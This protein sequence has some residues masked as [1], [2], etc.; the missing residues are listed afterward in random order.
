MYMDHSV[1]ALFFFS[2]YL[3]G[4]VSVSS[5]VGFLSAYALVFIA[6][7]GVFM[8]SGNGQKMSIV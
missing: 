1:L 2:F 3:G 8:F 4:G 5:R 7:R 6:K